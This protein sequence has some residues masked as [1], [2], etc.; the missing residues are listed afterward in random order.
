MLS[1]EITRQILDKIDEH[2]SHPTPDLNV[3]EL[4]ASRFQTVHSFGSVA[5]SETMHQLHT[6]EYHF[7]LEVPPIGE[8]LD[9][10][11]APSFTELDLDQHP[12]LF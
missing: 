1:H 3:Q 7:G 2:L 10:P 9:A 5:L 6:Q 11:H 4:V 12:R 8:P